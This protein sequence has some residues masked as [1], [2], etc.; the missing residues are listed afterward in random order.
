MTDPIA[1]DSLT[2]KYALPLLYAGQ[3]GKEVFINEALSRTDVLLHCAIQGERNDPAEESANGEVWLIGENPSGEWSGYSTMLACRQESGW[4]FVQPRDGLRVL[5][6]SNGQE[7]LFFGAW[8]KASK[9]VELLGGTTVDLEA[10]TAIS[11]LVASL[12]AMGILPPA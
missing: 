4:F 2:A 6:R 7:R 5:D 11:N 10:R 1:F 3:A 9:P 12:Q 8:R